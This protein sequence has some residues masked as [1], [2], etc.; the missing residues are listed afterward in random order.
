MVSFI[1]FLF[2]F[3]PLLF[4]FRAA[5]TRTVVS[6]QA[7]L[8]RHLES[9]RA[10]ENP[11]DPYLSARQPYYANVSVDP[12]GPPLSPRQ[13]PP[14]DSRRPSMVDTLRTS[15][16]RPP[17]PP[18]LTASPRRY[19]SVSAA[20]GSSPNHPSR[21][22]IPSVVTP[23]QPMPP[24]PL[25]SASSPPNPSLAR[26]H[27]SADIRQHGWPPPGI[28]PF[29]SPHHP[30]HPHHPPH[31]AA[32][33]PPAWP[34]SPHRTPNSSDQQVREVLA[35][36]EMGAPRRPPPEGYRHISPPVN[37]PPSS[38][39]LSA[40]NGLTFGSRYPRQESSLPAT[41]RSSMAS[42]VHSLLN[43]ADTAERSD[44]DLPDDRKRK[45]LE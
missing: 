29:P 44:E 9:V 7:E 27:T 36:Y 20:A 8:E 12:P 14:D 15:M 41:R 3:S 21:S 28:S 37:E 18:H 45:R 19:G 34:P 22:Q 13:M 43:P 11:H 10:L 23:Q 31:Q 38:S 24:Q 35:Q 40:E 32:P 39:M 6:M 4:I 42:N 1:S 33:P 25:S 17:M 2:L 16:I 26:R 5:L 30:H